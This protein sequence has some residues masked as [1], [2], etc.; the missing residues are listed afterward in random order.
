MSSSDELSTIGSFVGERIVLDDTHIAEVFGPDHPIVEGL[1]QLEVDQLVELGDDEGEARAWLIDRTDAVWMGL[2]AQGA[3]CRAEHV[4]GLI[5]VTGAERSHRMID[6]LAQLLGKDSESVEAAIAEQFG[7][8]Q[9][10]PFAD[11]TT[12][13]ITPL[14]AASQD[15]RFANLFRL[16]SMTIFIGVRCIQQQNILRGVGLVHPRLLKHL[17]LL[18]FPVM[19]LGFGV[20]DYKLSEVTTTPMPTQAI[21]V[22]FR[23]ALNE[24]RSG[25]DFMQSTRDMLIRNGYSI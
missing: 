9:L 6:D 13:D 19:D 22:D 10:G 7:V 14:G 8:T 4:E 21:G 15:A 17:P 5:R 20:L 1:I 23:V 16:V 11:L 24:L 2:F 18:G 3:P 25:S 12:L